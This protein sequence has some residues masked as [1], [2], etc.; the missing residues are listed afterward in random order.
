MKKKILIIIIWVLPYQFPPILFWVWTFGTLELHRFRVKWCTHFTLIVGTVSRLFFIEKI[1]LRNNRHL[2]SDQTAELMAIPLLVSNWQPPESR[3]LCSNAS[4]SEVGLMFFMIVHVKHKSKKPKLPR[5]NLP[6]PTHKD[7]EP[8]SV[9]T[10][11][12]FSA[13]RICFVWTLH[14]TTIS[15]IFRLVLIVLRGVF[16][17]INNRVN[18]PATRD[19]L[20]RD[21][22][23]KFLFILL[24]ILVQP[25]YLWLPLRKVT[26]LPNCLHWA[27]TTAEIMVL[28][29]TLIIQC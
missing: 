13:W 8:F 11:S 26:L 22:D 24:W 15:P 14:L 28:L 10:F 27:C 18:N 5:R 2:I 25:Y 23:Q 6:K 3:E 21:L 1:F 19:T 9:Q 29:I 12:Q 17:T 16:L 20:C 4:E 7:L